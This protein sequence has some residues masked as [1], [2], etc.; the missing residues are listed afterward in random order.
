MGTT[1]YYFTGTGNS[2]KVAKDLS[3]QLEDSNLIQISKK[4]ILITKGSS[5]NKIGFVYPVYFN[6][7]PLMVKKFIENLQVD[8]N[9][10]IFAVATFGGDSGISFNQ[11]DDIL[12]GKG[13]SISASFKVSMPGNYQVMY[14]PFS[15]EKQEKRFKNEE[16]QIKKIADSIKRNEVDKLVRVKGLKKTILGLIYNSFKPNDKD[17]N[18]WTTEK[19]NGCGICSR[20][21]PAG[22]INMSDRKPQWKHECEQCLAC[23]QWCP[24]KSIQY[25]KKTLR[26]GRYHHP[27]I[28]VNELFINN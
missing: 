9:T 3:E 13:A 8:A 1:I 10:Y 28:K 2:L 17:D 6:G 5:S 24:Q 11:I 4:S 22:N 12:N 7:I 23:M 16:E 18:F 26:R 21:C 19:C 27:K 14:S 20:I 25:K 15:Q